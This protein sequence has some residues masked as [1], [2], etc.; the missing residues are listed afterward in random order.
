M[1]LTCRNIYLIEN[2]VII[3]EGVIRGLKME[4]LKMSLICT[5]LFFM[6]FIGLVFADEYAYTTAYFYTPTDVSF[7]ITLLGD[8][9]ATDSGDT[10]PGPRTPSWIT[11]NQTGA[12]QPSCKKVQPKTNDTFV[13]NGITNPIIKVQNVGNT[14][15]FN[16]YLNASVSGDATI[17]LCAN[18]TVEGGTGS[19]TTP[20]PSTC[21]DITERSTWIA[22]AQG[23][24]VN[25][26]LDVTLYADFTSTGVGQRTGAIY[27]RSSSS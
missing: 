26:I 17:A 16:F 7:R 3:L 14:N 27:Y 15:Q 5:A 12:C 25:T 10:Q 4:K 8:T 1:K 6:G 24:N 11:F 22:F 9:V 18:G 20:P 21:T 2:K 13:Q 19:C 23:C